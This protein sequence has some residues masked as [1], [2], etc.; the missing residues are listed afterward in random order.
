MVSTGSRSLTEGAAETQ[1]EFTLQLHIKSVYMPVNEQT[2]V[3]VI[4]SR[5]NKKA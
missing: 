4:W 5:G 2:P 3:Q 1:R